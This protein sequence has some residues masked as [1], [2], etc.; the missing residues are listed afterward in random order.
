MEN[1]MEKAPKHILISQSTSE[2]GRMISVMAKEPSYLQMV[3][4]TLESG[5]MIPT[6]EKD[7]IIGQ[8]EIALQ[9]IFWMGKETEKAL[10]LMLTAVII[11]ADGKIIAQLVC[12]NTIK[13]TVAL[14][15]LNGARKM[16][17]K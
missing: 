4:A 17:S 9:V 15:T 11:L 3:R 13:Q 16:T 6:L 10:S 7:P 1:F 2:I 8:T 5:K 14:T 12:K